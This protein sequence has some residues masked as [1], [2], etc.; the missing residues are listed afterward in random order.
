MNTLEER[1]PST[2]GKPRPDYQVR[3][4]NDDGMELGPDMPGELLIR[5]IKPYSILLEYY[6]MPEKTVEAWRDM[7]FHTGDY[8]YY[9]EDGYFHFVDRKKDTFR[10]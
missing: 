3:V 8:L 2:C 10:R 7:W 4:V 6:R 5:P 1:K 9:D